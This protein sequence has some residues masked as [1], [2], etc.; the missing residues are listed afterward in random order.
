MR[1]HGLLALFTAKLLSTFGSWLT[2][3]ALP[4][5][6]LVSTGSP[7]TMSLVLT[8]EFAGVVIVGPCSGAMI[9]GLGARRTML[10]G[11][12]ARVPLMAAIPLLHLTGGLNLPILLTVSFAL[13]TCTAPYVSSQR[14][15]LPELLGPARGA[16]ERLVGRANSLVDAATRIAALAGPALGGVLI[17]V[18]GPPEVLWIDAGTY[19]ASFVIVLAFVRPPAAAPRRPRRSSPR[20]V[21]A[22]GGC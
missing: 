19:L 4:W 5:F 2:L 1:G 21:A 15:I 3:L 17:A 13:G 22:T 10:I 14:L 12:A 16:D 8:V 9:A 20:S 6:V 18:L 7:V 11:D